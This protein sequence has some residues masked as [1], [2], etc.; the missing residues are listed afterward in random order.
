MLSHKN[1]HRGWDWI[2]E[3]LLLRSQAMDE[4][5]LIRIHFSRLSPTCPEPFSPL[6]HPCR[7]LAISLNLLP[8][9]L[10]YVYLLFLFDLF[11]FYSVCLVNWQN[12]NQRLVEILR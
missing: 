10:L 3:M 4:E 1:T 12:F 11:T 8:S 7:A 5:M 9:L 2:V 6:L